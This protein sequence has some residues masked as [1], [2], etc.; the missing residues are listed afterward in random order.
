MHKFGIG[1][2]V[3]VNGKNSDDGVY[4]HYLDGSYGCVSDVI[5]GGS[6]YRIEFEVVVDSDPVA[7]AIHRY[8]LDDLAKQARIGEDELEPYEFLDKTDSAEFDLIFDS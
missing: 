8:K 6:T 4:A 3:I 2:C 7:R 1:D 5:N